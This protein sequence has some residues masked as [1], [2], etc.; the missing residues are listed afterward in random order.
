MF[1]RELHSQA[2]AY[3][4]SIDLNVSDVALK[5]RGHIYFWELIFRVDNQQTGFTTSTIANY[6]QLLPNGGHIALQIEG[7]GTKAREKGTI[8]SIYSLTSISQYVI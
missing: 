5:Y 4:L 3:L 2:S 8:A 1:R 6:D 7:T